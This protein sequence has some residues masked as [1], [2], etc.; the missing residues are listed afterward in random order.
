M[1]ILKT[2]SVGNGDLFYIKHCSSNFTIIDCNM[3]E[4]NRE[5]IVNEIISESKNKDIIRFISTHPDEDHIHGL[6]YLDQRIQILNF[7]CVENQARKK[8]ETEDFKHYCALRDGKHHYYVYEGCKRKW[9]NDDDNEKKYGSSGINFLWPQKNNSFYLEALDLA[10]EGDAFNNLSP[11]FTYSLNNGIT[12][13]WMGDMEHEFLENIQA[14]IDWPSVDILFA[15]HH[16]RHSGRVSKKVLDK[17]TP[18]I[19]IVGEAPSKYLNYF[20]GYNTLTQNSTGSIVFQNEAGKSHIF[21][22]HS[23]YPYNT[24]FLYDEELS[25]GEYGYYL[26]TLKV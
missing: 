6:K 18:K 22:E 15:P 20:E 24:S 16:G 25:D 9:M 8:D 19:I 3:D 26:G 17:L 4:N 12:C 23:H 5:N 7:Y 14:N 1:S 10:K 11:I 21:I 2:I 13:M